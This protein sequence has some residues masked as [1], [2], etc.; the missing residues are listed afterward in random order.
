MITL[1]SLEMDRL[2]ESARASQADLS[3]AKKRIKKLE[4]ALRRAGRHIGAVH[5][6]PRGCSCNRCNE[7]SRALSLKGKKR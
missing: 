4:K 5:G 7:I 2:R 6:D 3:A 1:L